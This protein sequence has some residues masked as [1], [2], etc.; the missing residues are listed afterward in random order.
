VHLLRINQVLDRTG[1]G[2]RSSLWRALRRGDFPSPKITSTNR[3]C[4]LEADI[5]AW[6]ASLPTRH[7]GPLETRPTAKSERQTSNAKTTTGEVRHD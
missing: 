5:E 2:S 7:Y 3:L 4:W 1:I 6:A